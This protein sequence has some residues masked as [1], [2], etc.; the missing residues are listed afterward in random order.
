MT[1]WMDKAAC[2]QVDPEIFHDGHLHHQAVH[3]C[4]AHCPVR[5]QCKQ[6]A[7]DSRPLA[8]EGQVVG[9]EVWVRHANVVKVGLNQPAPAS[10]CG[11]C[12][13]AA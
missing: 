13:S 1:A 5:G 6:W 8:W 3:V 2:T 7:H 10:K 11:L 4:F 12:R 9:G